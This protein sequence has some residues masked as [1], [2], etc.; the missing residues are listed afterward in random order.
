MGY[1]ILSLQAKE[2]KHA[3][4]KNDLSISNRSNKSSA[5]GKRWQ[6]IQSN[7]IRSFY[8]P[9]HQP[10]P[11]SYTLHFRSRSPRHCDTIE[12]CACGRT[13]DDLN[14]KCTVCYAAKTVVECARQKKLCEEII[15]IFKPILCNECNE[16]FSDVNTLK[17]HSEAIHSHCASSELALSPDPNLL[18]KRRLSNLN[19]GQLKVALKEKGLSTSGNKDVLIKHLEGTLSA[20]L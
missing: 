15:T 18:S 19:V 8:L 2:S 1:G 4:I 9:E 5:G 6:V 3:A 14:E 13:R 7:Y 11:P 10:A 20:R 16:H 17:V 12:F